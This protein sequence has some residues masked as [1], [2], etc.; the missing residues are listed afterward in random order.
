M[1]DPPAPKS[2]QRVVLIG[3]LVVCAPV[4]HYREHFVFAA[5]SLDIQSVDIA[6]PDIEWFTYPVLNKPVLALQMVG[7]STTSVGQPLAP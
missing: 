4:E 2:A 6:C 1:D 5:S 7:N 3:R